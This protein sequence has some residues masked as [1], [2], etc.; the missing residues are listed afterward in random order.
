MKANIGI[1]QENINKVVDVLIKVLA[2][3]FVL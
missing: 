1:K 3:E 2:D